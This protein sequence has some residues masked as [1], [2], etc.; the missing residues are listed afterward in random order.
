[1]KTLFKIFTFIMLATSLVNAQFGPGGPGGMGQRSDGNGR[2]KTE[3]APTLNLDGNAPKGNSK[4]F[5]FVIDESVS[6]VVEFANVALY[7]KET[8][9][10]VDG[11]VADE[12]GKF[13][14]NRIAAGEYNLVI[15]FIGFKDKTIEVKVEKGKDNDMGVIKL[16]Q[17]VKQLDEVTVTA[18]KSMIEEKVDRLVY[19]AEK[20][21]TSKGGDA[22]DILRKVPMLSVDLDGNVSLRGTSNLKVLINNKPSTIVA[23]SIADALK[24]IPADLIKTVEVITSPSAK[25]DAEGSGG[26][27]NIILKKSTLQGLTLNLDSGV[28]IRGSNLSLNGNY[29]QG[30]LGVTLGGFGRAFYNKSYTTLDQSTIKNGNTILTN[31]TADAYDNGL[32]GRYNLGFDYDLAKNQS[33]T[34]SVAFGTRNFTRTQ[35][36]TI[37]QFTNNLLNSTSFRDVTSKDLSNSVD[38]N[39]DYI[40]T[41]KP[42]QE[43]SVSGQFSQNKLTN[44]FDADLLSNSQELLSRQKNLNKNFNNEIT[45]QT[46]YQ[47]PIK[48][49]QMFEVG[50]KTV[51][52]QVN[53]DY[54]YRIAGATGSFATDAR[55][56]AG[57]LNY[58]QNI[59]AGYVSYTFTTKKKL[60]IKAGTRYEYTSITAN[61]QNSDIVIPAYGNLVPSINISKPV[62]KSSTLKLA[63]NNRIQRPGLQQLN[64]NY[65]AANPQSISIG[66]PSLKP[67]I[68]N[69]VELSLSTNIKKTYLNVSL[70]GRQTNN[71]ITRITT[72]SDTLAGAVI[73]TFQN[74]GK[75]QTFGTNIFGNFFITSKWTINGGIDLFYNYLEGQQVGVNGISSTISNS[76]IVIGGRLQS[77]LSLKNGW[78]VQAFGGYRGNR[79]QLQGTQGGM[80]MYSIGARKDFKNKKG[81]LGLAVDNIFGGM[82]M[83]STLNSPQFS[84]VSVNNIYNQNIKLTFSYKIGK[85]KFTETKKTKVKNDDVK[86]GADNN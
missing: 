63:Y 6:T 46:D 43:W 78:A 56:P 24:M 84:Q 32:F 41:F 28:G 76:G 68:S 49:N 20:D 57:L 45:L 22:A 9:K 40:R 1:M 26:I 71:S 35:D 47:T 25:Y 64:P 75:E 34:A 74:I 67:E 31:Q 42:S 65:N 38:I 52:R 3:Q 14:M 33:L 4:I 29:R 66:N 61:D 36:Y 50:L 73:S 59:A 86:A 39:L 27:I 2:V 23:S 51:I 15:T 77:Q 8:K 10:V 60:T 48:K 79:V 21:L 44:N 17:N 58:S 16:A 70:F 62:G 80:G 7:N 82:V 54:E 81:S 37:N 5:G 11:T 19:N 53:S 72:P 85:M 13:S 83:R 30:K 18:E 69:N 55:N 12:K